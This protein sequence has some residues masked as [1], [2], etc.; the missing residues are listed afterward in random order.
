[1]GY[2]SRRLQA[3]T[4]YL[5]SLDTTA[6]HVSVGG[7]TLFEY[8][9]LRHQSY[10]ASARKSFLAALY[11]K[12]VASGQIRLDA[13]LAELGITDVGGLLPREA[14]AKKVSLFSLR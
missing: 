7:K 11:G 5:Q 14:Q 12:Y 1:M 10:L 6:V 2:S 3:I 4:A 13:T 9:D 8:G